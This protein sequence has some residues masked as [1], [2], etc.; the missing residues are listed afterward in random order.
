LFESLRKD[1]PVLGVHT[2]DLAER[3]IKSIGS[4]SAVIL[5]WV[6]DD[7]EKLGE[8][9][10]P[11][12]VRF[13]RGDENRTLK[14]LEDNDFYS[15]VYVY[16][17]EDVEEQFGQRL[18]DRFGDRIRFQKKPL[19]PA[20]EI[21]RTLNEW[22]DQNQN[23]SI[24][25]A[26]TSTINLAIQQIFKELADADD[27]WVKELGLSAQLDGVSGE[28]F[29]I[30]ILQ[31]LLTE[32]L[33][34][35]QSL[36]SSIGG[37][38]NSEKGDEAA[39]KEESVARLFKRLLYTKLDEKASIMTGDICALGDDKFGIIITPECDISDVTSGK[40]PD[41]ELLVF[42]K[43]S[44]DVFLALGIND[45]Y[46]RSAFGTA[47]DKQKD[48]LRKIF[49]QNDPK[50]HVLPSFP[51]DDN[52]FNLSVAIDFSKGAERY[53]LEKIKDSRRY[54]LNSPFIQQVRQRYISHL[55]RVGVPS[56]PTSLRDFNLRSDAE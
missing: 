3:A 4:F 29:V 21:V 9:A 43:D 45:Q 19:A 16:S 54:K 32:M 14:F 28:L 5:D 34:Q 13:V 30:E 40:I 37:Y 24:P 47:K 53:S 15:L 41:F 44:F 39:P 27:N 50:Y 48:K 17:T 12:D 56:L 20:T 55:G 18:R 8:G 52:S 23:L 35:N 49:N 33:V 6:F 31:F 42:L 36:L 7:K 1:Y 10:D 25:L 46:K 38:L 26:W 2:L 51:I 22:R 11:E